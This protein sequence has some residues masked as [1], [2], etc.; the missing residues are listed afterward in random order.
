MFITRKQYEKN[1]RKA[2]KQGAKEAY[3]RWSMQNSI[4][5]VNRNMYD[6]VDRLH[7]ELDK[8]IAR[9]DKLENK[10]NEKKQ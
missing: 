2:K 5:S 8:V 7:M 9:L 1:L 4:D 3:E 10:R 6:N